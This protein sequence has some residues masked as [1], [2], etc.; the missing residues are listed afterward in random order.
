MRLYKK[1]PRK[2][3][4]RKHKKRTRQHKKR[5]RQHKK[6][7]RRHKRKRNNKGGDGL[8]YQLFTDVDDTLHPAGYAAVGW[9]EIAGVDREGD[10][11]EYY[12]C[13]K[14][15]HK[16]FNNEFGLPTV[17]VSANPKTSI[18]SGKIKYAEA[19][20]MPLDAIEYMGGEKIASTMSVL[21]NLMPTLSA[22]IF[23]R[24]VDMRENIHYNRMARVK[25]GHITK[26]VMEMREEL[27]EENYRA[28]WIGDNGQ[29]DLLAANELLEQGLI[30]AALIHHVNPR[31]KSGKGTKWFKQGML[32]PFENYFRAINWLKKFTGLER[33]DIC[34]E[35]PPPSLHQLKRQNSF[36]DAVSPPYQPD[37]LRRRS[38]FVGEDDGY[39]GDADEDDG[40]VDE[41]KGT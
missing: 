18:E 11:S 35:I 13:A 32:Y 21:E 5:T 16:W 36:E 34:Q 1:R 12:P 22:S 9:F 27:G 15:L 20:E 23:R 37:V 29:G 19:L 31:K 3:T 26:K 30:Y 40:Y 7:T 17:I 25:I 39:D 14:E 24:G 4:I 33:L 8:R 2:K 41:K 6:R 28:I 10:R 38:R